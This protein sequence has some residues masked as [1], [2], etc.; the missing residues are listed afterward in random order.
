MFVDIH[1]HAL[2]GVDDGSKQW[3]MTLAMFKQAVEQGISHLVLTPHYIEGDERYSQ[4]AVLSTFERAKQLIRDQGFDLRLFLGNEVFI[5]EKNVERLKSRECMTLNNTGYVLIE[6]P[7]YIMTSVLEDLVYD[8]Q[9][10]GYQV[11]FAH[12][13]RYGWLQKRP[14]LFRKFM[15]QGVLMQINATSI[16]SNDWRTR[17]RVKRLIMNGMVHVVASDAHDD[18]KRRFRLREAYDLVGNKFGWQVAN[19]LFVENPLRIIRDK[20]VEMPGIAH[21]GFW[22]RK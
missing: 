15:N 7:D 17:R 1:S 12:I 2:P 13:E 21:T 3:E 6:L 9:L 22:R 11:V 4:D 16:V 10:E 14:T 20:H 18:V 8:I 19:R 5:D